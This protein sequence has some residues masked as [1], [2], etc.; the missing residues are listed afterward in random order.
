MGLGVGL[1]NTGSINSTSN[2]QQVRLGRSSVQPLLKKHSETA[3]RSLSRLSR[4]GGRV[5]SSSELRHLLEPEGAAGA[6]EIDRRDFHLGAQRNDARGGQR[7]FPV[8]N[9]PE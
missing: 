9:H 6:R 5:Y 3:A 8:E 4:R 1:V 2:P 7:L